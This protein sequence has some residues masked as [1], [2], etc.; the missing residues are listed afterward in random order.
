VTWS[1]ILSRN[2][3][4]RVG[5]PRAAST[6]RTALRL[7]WP[8]GLAVTLVLAAGD[9]SAATCSTHSV[10]VDLNSPG[11]SPFGAYLG[12]SIGQSFFAEDTL[13]RSITV[14]RIVSQDSNA[15]GIH[16][17]IVEVDSSGTPR[18]D[19]LVVDWPESLVRFGAPAVFRFEFDPPIAL[20][21]RD[22]FAFY[23]TADPC[24]GSFDLYAAF[25]SYPGG[26]LWRSGRT[27]GCELRAF[28]DHVN[29][30]LC[31]EIEF[32]DVPTPTRHASW[33]QLKQH[34]R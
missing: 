15:F 32:C 1:G 4:V 19:R 16:L 33:G 29:A 22:E 11:G 8:Y 9:S 5:R 23:L 10:G 13:I 6:L 27:D 7:A 20:P 21:R 34:Y 3:P 26:S 25:D 14:W 2:L 31:F 28:P 17:R 18:G 24:Y 30:D 12:R